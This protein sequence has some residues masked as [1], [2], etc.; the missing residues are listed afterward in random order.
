MTKETVNVNIN[1]N[2]TSVGAIAFGSLLL[3][4]LV[5]TFFKWIIL[6][7]IVTTIVVA[8]AALWRKHQRDAASQAHRDAETMRRADEQHRWVFS[9]DPRGMF[10]HSWRYSDEGQI[11]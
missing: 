10:G 9:G 6:G 1:D 11:T 2:R 4:A 3:L 8:T 5:M 7:V